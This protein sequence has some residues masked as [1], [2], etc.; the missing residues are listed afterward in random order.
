MSDAKWLA[1]FIDETD[2]AAVKAWAGGICRGLS[3][4]DA[5]ALFETA[6]TISAVVSEVASGLPEVTR[7]IAERACETELK[8]SDGK[9]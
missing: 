1:G 7:E 9:T 2:P 3:L 8:R 5:A 4:P 6:P